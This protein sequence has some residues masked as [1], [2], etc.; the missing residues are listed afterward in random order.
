MTKTV[1]VKYKDPAALKSSLVA[2]QKNQSDSLI[3][4]YLLGL[5]PLRF[6]LIL[7][8]LI[9]MQRLV[10]FRADCRVRQG[11]L[12]PSLTGRN[13]R[14]GPDWWGTLLLMAVEGGEIKR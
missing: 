6:I 8:G 14:G 4:G 9:Y 7:F 5:F 13:H 11:D 10:V 12:H 3:A 2:V 1:A